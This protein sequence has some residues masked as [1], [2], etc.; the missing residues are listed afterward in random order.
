[1]AVNELF[2]FF[3]CYFGSFFIFF[4]M[5]SFTRRSLIIWKHHQ[6]NI[7][8]IIF[9]FHL[10]FVLLKSLC[11]FHNKCESVDS[12]KV[13]LDKL[14]HAIGCKQPPRSSS[15]LKLSNL[16]VLYEAWAVSVALCVSPGV[17]TNVSLLPSYGKTTSIHSS[18]VIRHK[19]AR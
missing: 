16:V 1:M 8:Y 15:L 12:P 9:F 2:F 19:R 4:D 10:H 5:T 14:F 3:F 13:N 17:V 11:H 18:R 6:E 7:N